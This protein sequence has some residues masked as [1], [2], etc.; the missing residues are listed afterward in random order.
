[1]FDSI[2]AGNRDLYL[3]G[4]DG[5]APRRLTHDPSEEIAGTWSRDS[6]FIYFQSDRTG[7]AETWRI[8]VAEGRPSR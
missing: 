1:M 4:A 8:P 7:R 6:R 5:G 3:V 2:E